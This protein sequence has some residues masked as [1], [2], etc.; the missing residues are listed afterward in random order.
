MNISILAVLVI[1]ATSFLGCAAQSKMP[2]EGGAAQMKL[3]KEMP[4]D[5][6]M[7]FGSNGGMSVYY[8]SIEIAGETL[9][10]KARTT[11]TKGQE[12]IW[13]AKISPADKA[14]LYKLFVENKFD[15]IKNEKNETITYD[16]GSEGVSL[17]FAPNISY[18]VQS[19]ANFPLSATNKMRYQTI[20]GAIE[21]LAQKYE[22][23]KENPVAV[24][25][26][27]ARKQAVAFFETIYTDEPEKTAYQMK[28]TPF[29]PTEWNGSTFTKWVSYVY[30]SGFEVSVVDGERTAKLFAKIIFNPATQ[31]AALEKLS[32]KLEGGDIQGVKPLPKV[33]LAVL[34]TEQAVEKT[35]L[36]TKNRAGLI[37]KNTVGIA[38]FY[39]TWKKYNGVIY[40]QFAG[41][42]EEFNQWVDD[43]LFSNKVNK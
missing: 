20:A 14:D 35:L 30:A 22:A 19:G 8:T 32:G 43:K 24:S 13:T 17:S 38:A 10:Y 7:S 40:Q 11:V 41:H 12:V 23:M 15:Q 6:Q 18:N 1:L 9:T 33:D 28:F 42:H 36:Q 16:A 34:K 4:A 29:F 39:Q 27:D 21:K 26:T 37:A 31:S 25:L 2:E 5:V 3:P